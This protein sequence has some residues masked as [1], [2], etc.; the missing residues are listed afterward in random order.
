MKIMNILL[1]FLVAIVGS[2]LLFDKKA[3]SQSSVDA[4]NIVMMNI[5]DGKKILVY[6]KSSNTFLI[7]GNPSSG[8][9]DESLQLL[10]I[11]S[12]GQDFLMAEKLSQ[13]ES[14][15]VLNKKGYTV[16]DIRQKVDVALPKRARTKTLQGGH[17]PSPERPLKKK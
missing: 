12:L 2:F 7:Y 17:Y 10:Q 6:H 5:Q 4:G 8:S 15:L 14:E 16:E 13:A 11:R 1:I 3:M 9:K